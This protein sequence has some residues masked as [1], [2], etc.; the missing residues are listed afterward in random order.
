MGF[1]VQYFLCNFEQQQQEGGVE[2]VKKKL[3]SVKD[4]QPAEVLLKEFNE[5]D[6]CLPEHSKD[7]SM[8]ACEFQDVT[9]DIRIRILIGM[10]LSRRYQ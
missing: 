10:W 4:R 2:E 1:L 6:D 8:K 5:A 3:T 7:V 9:N